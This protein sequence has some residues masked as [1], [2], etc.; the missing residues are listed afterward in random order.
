MTNDVPGPRSGRGPREGETASPPKTVVVVGNGNGIGQACAVRFA[1]EGMDVVCV[2][3]VAAD[4]EQTCQRIRDHGGQAFSMV[5]DTADE[6]AMAVIASRC[7]DLG[8]DVSSLVNCHMQLEWGTVEGTS[9]I[10]WQNALRHN[11]I[12]PL[13]CTRAFLPLLKEARGAAVVHVGSVD[14][15]FGNPM[16]ASYSVAKA[17][18][19]PLTHV[20]AYEFAPYG[21]RVNCIARAAVAEKTGTDGLPARL[22]AETP[23]GRAAGSDE[24]AAAV[25]FL[26][27]GEASYVT[28]AVVPVDG[29]RTA[30]TPGTRPEAR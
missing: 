28:G 18:L 7:H 8:L 4:I 11:L 30:I 2:D 17:G 22:L 21:I 13:V 24:V 9:L 12:G 3:Q 16:A 19:V 29:G 6:T 5:S 1:R 15:T 25:W 20:M 23:M 26:A 27:S 14:G 10:A